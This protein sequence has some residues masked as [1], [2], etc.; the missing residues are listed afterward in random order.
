MKYDKDNVPNGYYKLET[1]GSSDHPIVRVMDIAGKRVVS[2]INLN[3]PTPL[4]A[5][6]ANVKFAKSHKNELGITPEESAG[7][8]QEMAAYLLELLGDDRNLRVTRHSEGLYISRLDN[9]K[10]FFFNCKPVM[11]AVGEDV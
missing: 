9:N 4:N 11:D 7:R 2:F 10:R 8:E 3:D 1:P 5:I 6:A